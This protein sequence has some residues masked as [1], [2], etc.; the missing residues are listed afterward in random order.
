MAQQ[1]IVLEI[2]VEVDTP[3]VNR[4]YGVPITKLRIEGKNK[5]IITIAEGDKSC[6]QWREKSKRKILK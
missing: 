1:N 2:E 5:L 4:T 3:T 6:F